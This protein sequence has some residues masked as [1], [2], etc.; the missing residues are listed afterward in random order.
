VVLRKFT[1]TPASGLRLA[2]DERERGEYPGCTTAH[3]GIGIM[4]STL[5]WT[6]RKLSSDCTASF[7]DCRA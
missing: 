7:A 3:T 2:P 6:L 1:I 5:S 4:Q